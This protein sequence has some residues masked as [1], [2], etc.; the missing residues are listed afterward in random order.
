MRKT[1]SCEAKG[2][3]SNIQFFYIN[4]NWPFPLKNQLSRHK[5]VE[6]SAVEAL[7]WRFPKATFVCSHLT[8]RNVASPV[9][10]KY[11][12][13]PHPRQNSNIYL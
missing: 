1:D 3:L 11:S 7:N 2:D 10:F 5:P 12:V 4:D 13:T 6:A 8:A 9:S